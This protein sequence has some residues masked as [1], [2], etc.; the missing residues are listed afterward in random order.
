M[1]TQTHGFV[2]VWVNQ[3]E[4]CQLPQCTCSGSR[5]WPRSQTPS[6]II[7]QE[8][9]Y[10]NIPQEWNCVF[11]LFGKKQ[12]PLFFY[13]SPCLACCLEE[14]SHF[15]R[16]SVAPGSLCHPWKRERLFMCR[17]LCPSDPRV[18]PAVIMWSKSWHQSGEE[19]CLFSVCLVRVKWLKADFTFNP[20]PHH[21]REKQELMMSHC[22]PDF[23]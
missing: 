19:S 5:T 2:G 22:V 11:H 1:H 13:R 3:C 4:L 10:G 7:L 21:E 6:E 16:G 15:T 14:K 17:M 12:P 23:Y 9:G 8:Q 18:N 20:F